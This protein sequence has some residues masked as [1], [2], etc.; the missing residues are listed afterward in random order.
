MYGGDGDDVLT[1][2]GGGNDAYYGGDGN[3]LFSF[4]DTGSDIFDGGAG[5][6]T[7]AIFGGDLSHSTITG[8]ETLSIGNGTYFLATAA[9]INSFTTVSLGGGGGAGFALG[10][11]A[12]GSIGSNFSTV[13]GAA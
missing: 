12:A 4:G 7:L 5:N 10:L 9:E 2:G 13:N 11:T 1:G 6:D 8:I 3:D